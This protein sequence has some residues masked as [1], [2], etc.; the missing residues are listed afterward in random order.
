M[1]RPEHIYRN[2]KDVTVCSPELLK[3]DTDDGTQMPSLKRVCPCSVYFLSENEQ[4]NL[5]LIIIFN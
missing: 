2:I 5:D 1:C 4:W 3:S